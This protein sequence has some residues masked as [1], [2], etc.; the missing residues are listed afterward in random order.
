MNH[1]FLFLTRNLWKGDQLP[2]VKAKKPTDE[3]LPSPHTQNPNGSRAQYLQGLYVRQL[4]LRRDFKILKLTVIAQNWLDLLSAI[5]L[6][7]GLPE[8]EARARNPGLSHRI[9]E[10]RQA[11]PH[12]RFCKPKILTPRAGLNRPT[13]PTQSPYSDHGGSRGCCWLL[14]SGAG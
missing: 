12:P 3:P 5:N 4:T 10:T 9:K 6:N 7:Q 13:T 11:K 2:I 14:S 8:G 1:R